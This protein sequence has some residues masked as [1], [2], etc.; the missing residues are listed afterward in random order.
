MK[1]AKTIF[2]LAI[3]MLALAACS[4]GNTNSGNATSEER[5]SAPE[6]T[7]EPT[8]EPKTETELNT[9]AQKA[10]IFPIEF[11]AYEQD[12]V[13]RGYDMITGE[14]GNSITKIY[15]DGV[16]FALG[17]NMHSF[18]ACIF[19]VETV[20]YEVLESLSG[21][22]LSE[23]VPID[24]LSSTSIKY[25]LNY[26]LPISDYPDKITLINSQTNEVIISFN[27]DDVYDISHQT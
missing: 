23:G 18:I 2:W 12:F 26:N 24:A 20:E 17:P 5:I 10:V 3:V 1:T 19:E 25:A 9:A 13:L 22:I 27:V 16:L 14:D 7:T 8:T 4:G 6:P 15:C 21:D 11:S